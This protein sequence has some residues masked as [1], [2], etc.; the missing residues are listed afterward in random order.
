RQMKKIASEI[1]P[2]RSPV[3]VRLAPSTEVPA[4]RLHPDAAAE[5]E[6]GF[7][8]REYGT[9]YGSRPRP[10]EDAEPDPA[11]DADAVASVGRNGG[12]GESCPAMA[13]GAHG[14]VCR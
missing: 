3:R 8:R 1:A 11:Q 9:E 5:F 6:L 12:E 2:R 14:C 4:Y 13:E 7:G 10:S